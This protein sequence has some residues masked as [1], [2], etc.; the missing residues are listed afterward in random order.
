MGEIL[1]R[2]GNKMIL[3]GNLEGVVPLLDLQTAGGAATAG[4]KDD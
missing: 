2:M 1:P 4:K 3:D